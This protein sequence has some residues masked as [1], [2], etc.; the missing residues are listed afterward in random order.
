MFLALWLEACRGPDQPL[1]LVDLTVDSPKRG[2]DPLTVK[3]RLAAVAFAQEEYDSALE[4]AAQG[5]R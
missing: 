3:G 4:E 5:G 2:G 1:V